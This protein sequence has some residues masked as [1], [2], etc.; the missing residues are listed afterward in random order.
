[1]ESQSSLQIHNL[2]GVYPETSRRFDKNP[3]SSTASGTSFKTSLS[4]SAV[5]DVYQRSDFNVAVP[6]ERRGVD[7]RVRSDRR[8]SSSPS[9]LLQSNI[10][11]TNVGKLSPYQKTNRVVNTHNTMPA[12]FSPPQEKGSLIDVWV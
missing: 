10:A 12:S 3:D 4:E 9:V 8:H 11:V 7:R 2:N 1:M 5:V 6:D